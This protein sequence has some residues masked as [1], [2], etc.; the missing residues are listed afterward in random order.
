L[1]DI[2]LKGRNAIRD[3][4]NSS[5]SV[6][7]FPLFIKF[8]SGDFE[9]TKIGVSV[10]KRNFKHAVDRNRIKRQLR[11]LVANNLEEINSKFPKSNLFIIYTAQ[12]KPT[13]SV[14]EKALNKIF[15][16]HD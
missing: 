15:I 2:R 7:A 16:K 14:L 8:E 13:Y 11:S 9:Q 10:S 3:V 5:T 12:E 4:F 6:R 1:T